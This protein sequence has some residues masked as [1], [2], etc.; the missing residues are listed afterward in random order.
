MEQSLQNKY[1]L[2]EKELADSLR[3]VE[4]IK[5][6][7]WVDNNTLL[8]NCFPE[9]SSILTQLINHRLSS[10][11]NNELFEVIN[12]PMPY[13]SMSQVWDQEDRN[14]KIYIKFLAEWTRKYISKHYKYLFI[15]YKMNNSNFARLRSMLKGKLELDNY[16]LAI[17][18]VKK[19]LGFP[20][21][22]P[23]YFA[24]EYEND[25]IFQWENM[26]NPDR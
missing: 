1:I 26:N 20:F 18:Y 6:D 2:F 9:Y 14:Y 7:K 22:N 15:G 24:E 16:R 11:N 10:V 8:V 17:Q 13:T 3:L 12:L 19:D 23:D 25:I 4:R 5:Q 21:P